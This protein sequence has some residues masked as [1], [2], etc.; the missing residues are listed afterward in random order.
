MYPPGSELDSRAWESLRS[1]E[2]KQLAEAVSGARDIG[3]RG[4]LLKM[5]LKMS[6]VKR[7]AVCAPRPEDGISGAA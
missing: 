4:K 6:R 5:T 3:E 2:K 1:W 7:I